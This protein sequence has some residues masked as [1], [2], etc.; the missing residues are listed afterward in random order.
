[1]DFDL[2]TEQIQFQKEF[3]EYLEK[4]LTP[5]IIEERNK[6]KNMNEFTDPGTFGRGEYGG[7]KSKEFIRKMGEDGWLGVGWP[8]EYGG[9]GRTAVEQHLF[10]ETIMRCQAPFPI[11]TLNTVGPGIM[12]FGTEEQ[13]ETFLP[14]I[15]KGDLEICVGYTEPEAGTDLA[16][17]R[18]KAV[19]DGDHYIINGQKIFTSFAHIAD[20][21]WLATRTDPNA[22]KK[23]KGISMFLVDIDTPGISI[24]PIYKLSG[25]RVNSVFL[26]DVKVHK[27]CMVGEE[28]KGWQVITGQL[29]HERIAM[30]P[31]LY[32]K[33]R[34]EKGIQ[35][36]KDT[37][38]DG[39]PVIDRPGVREILA[40]LL[41]E[42]ETLKL[43]NYQVVD[44]MEK[45]EMI[46][47]ESSAVKVFASDLYLKS[48]N[49]LLEILGNYGQL[50]RGDKWAP[51]D[52]DIEEAYRMDFIFA[53]A[54][55]VNEVQRD[56]IAMAGLGMPKSR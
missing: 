39:T 34:I 53:I 47:A 55:G 38:I 32:V 23:H 16:S 4:H 46:W 27:S 52:G 49:A 8:K 36:A 5:D 12:K 17:L 25:D 21:I 24:D 7:P 44:K 3:G 18:T 51:L 28:N 1:M 50:Q 40:E 13:K 41:A 15:L 9:Q 20:Y 30:G 2:T 33:D 14:R 35:W 56:I 26:E 54:G 29:E 6:T 37:K 22:P 19:K 45:G 31:C 42:T 43:L 10:S 11:L 48:G